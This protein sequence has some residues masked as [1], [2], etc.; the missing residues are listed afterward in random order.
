MK[1]KNKIFFLIIGIIIGVIA[2]SIFRGSGPTTVPVLIEGKP[3]TNS[4]QGKPDT[5]ST[6]IFNQGNEILKP[7]QGSDEKTA[8]FDNT[9]NVN[10]DNVTG[11]IDLNIKTF[12]AVDSIQLD[13][14]MSLEAK[15]FER[16]DTIKIFRVDTL[17][18]PFEKPRMFYD[19][20]ETGFGAAATLI[21]VLL[22]II[23]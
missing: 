13:W 16:V 20:F 5:I 18:V 8:L 23:K 9:I 10:D 21:A 11:W 7:Q 4:V 12:P 2:S 17:K 3:D 15:S 14:F 1:S 6:S 22:L 19:N